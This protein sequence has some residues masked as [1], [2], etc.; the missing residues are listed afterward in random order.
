MTVS[1]RHRLLGAFETALLIGLLLGQGAFL[2]S[3]IDRVVGI[4]A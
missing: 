4:A 3:V 2:L 1:Q